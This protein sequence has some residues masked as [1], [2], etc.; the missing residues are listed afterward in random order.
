MSRSR[1]A[2]TSSES[3]APGSDAVWG[4]EI[5]RRAAA[6]ADRIDRYAATPDTPLHPRLVPATWALLK[7][8]VLSLAS[9]VVG[10]AVTARAVGN[11][12]EVHRIIDRFPQLIEDVM[13]GDPV[14]FPMARV[15]RV[16]AGERWFISSDLH[17][18]VAGHLDWPHAQ[19]T[20][21][22]YN[23]ALSFYGRQEWGLI[24]NGD[25]EEFWLVGGSAYGVLYDVS[26]MLAAVLP[27]TYGSGLRDVVYAEHFRRIV[28]NNEPTYQAVRSGFHD[29]GRFRRVVGNHDDCW[30]DPKRLP[31]LTGQFPGLEVTDFVVLEGEA[32]PVGVVT[33]GHQTDSWNGPAVNNS[34]ARLTSSSGSAVH[35]SPFPVGPGLPGERETRSLLSGGEKDRLGE[36]S[37]LTG[38]NADLESLDEV[39]LF[40]SCRRA[41]GDGSADLDGGP[42]LIMGHTHIPLSA[43]A[44]DADGGVWRRY[45]NSGSGITHGAVTGIEWDGSAGTAGSGP[46]VRLVA[47]VHADE[48]TPEEAIVS[49][50]GNGRIARFELRRNEDEGTLDVLPL[51][52]DG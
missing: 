28:A 19:D 32:G 39:R 12:R 46:A 2:M 11:T 38:V 52:A 3:T 44:L 4:S 43:P 36:V 14:D 9:P 22:L 31:L 34:I 25:I 50:N 30:E 16:S 49:A 40:E 6:L 35:D 26:R 51:G 10:S 42:W 15:S 8:A 45:L 48:A 1:T 13:V 27:D 41:W 20:V 29:Q 33:H 18:S 37:P 7:L 23:A 17:R 5:Y 21:G 24:E 47:W